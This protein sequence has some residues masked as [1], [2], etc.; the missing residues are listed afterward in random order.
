M[1]THYQYII[2]GAGCAGL[3]LADAL[4]KETSLTVGS[5]L[6]LEANPQ[7]E[8]KTWCFWQQSDHPYQHLVKKTWKKISFGAPAIAVKGEL[9]NLCYQYISSSDF[10]SH[11]LKLLEQDSRVDIIYEKANTITFINDIP[12]VCIDAGI[13][14]AEYIFYSYPIG[15]PMQTPTLWQH[16]LGWEIETTEPVFADDTATM[17]DFSLTDNRDAVFFHYLLPFSSTTAL[18]ECTFFSAELVDRSVYEALLT[19]YIQEYIRVPFT[20]RTKEEGK[21]PMAL[22]A[23]NI[24]SG[25]SKIIPIG[26]AAGCIKASTGY[27]FTR[28][29]KHTQQVIRWLKSGIPMRI[30][31]SPRRFLF[32]D[33]LFLSLIQQYPSRM[34]G[35]FSALFKNN[36]VNTILQFL[37]E[38]TSLW[39]EALIFLRLPKKYFLKVLLNVK[40]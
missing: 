2:I 40:R 22:T 24:H 35:I 38:D 34:P 10:F 15:N 19:Q 31:L 36:P 9:T 28:C 7:H 3:Q 20:L 21:I 5:L 25:T 8:P 16:F 39:Q 32:Y 12:Q 27:S 23:N 6:I 26:T 11:Q 18:V 1:R 13:I 30:P 14:S 33:R 4:L 29:M 37:D 17:M